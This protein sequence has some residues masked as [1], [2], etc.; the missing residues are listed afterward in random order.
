M[1]NSN[2]F[3]R[4]S[5][6]IALLF[7]NHLISQSIDYYYTINNN[8][9]YLYKQPNKYLLDFNSENDAMI[10]LQ[11]ITTS[12]VKLYSK[13]Y[14]V[15]D[16]DDSSVTTNYKKYPTYLTDQGNPMYYKDDIVLKFKSGVDASQINALMSSNNLT[17]L[18]TTVS[19]IQFKVQSDALQTSKTIY[20]TGLVEFCHPNFIAEVVGGYEGIK[21]DVSNIPEIL[22]P[23]GSFNSYSKRS[24]QLKDTAKKSRLATAIYLPSDEYF[25]KQWYLNNT[26]QM[27]NDGHIGT[28]DADID[29]PEAWD[30]TM[31]NNS[32]VVAVIDE[33]VSSNHPDL[34]NTRQ[35]RLP[36]S[37]I[38]FQFDGTNNPD[39][40]SPIFIAP[41]G[42]NHGNGCAGIIAATK[43]HEG[44][45]G[46]SPFCRIMPVKIIY[47]EYPATMCADAINFAVTNNTNI[48]NCSWAYNNNDPNFLPVIISAIE[49]AISNNIDVVFGAGNGANHNTSYNS[50]VAFPANNN[51]IGLI[52]V[53]ASDRNNNQ[54]NYSP[55]GT[56]NLDVVAPSHT[57]YNI[58]IP[59]EAFNIWTIDVPGELSGNNPYINAYPNDIPAVGETLPNGGTNYL[60][61]T[62]RFGGTSA[63]APQVAGV[64]ALVRS[65]NSCLSL[66][67]RKALIL[68]TADKVG[69]YNYASN[70]ALPGHSDELGYGKLN[71]FRAVSNAQFLNSPTLDLLVKDSDDDMGIQPNTTTLYPWASNDIW[72][73]NHND[74]LL[75]HQNPEYSP[76]VPNYAYIR[77]TNKSCVTSQANNNNIV[78]LYW[79]KAGT[80]LIWPISWNGSSTFSNNSLMGNL[81]GSVSIPQIAPGEEAIVR[82][83]FLVP[84]PS[85]YIFDGSDAW[86]FCL[87]ARIESNQD[88]MAIPETSDL[89]SNVLN[90]NNI[91]W[92]NITIVDLLANKLN[93]VIAVG[94]PF[95]EPRNFFLELVQDE[96]ET[97]K[98]V[99]DEAEVSLIMDDVLYAA[100]QRGGNESKLLGD[101][102]DEKTKIVKGN[103][104]KL[105]NIFFNPNEI[106]TLN[107]AFNF[108][109]KE[110]TDKTK[111]SYHVVQK[112]VETGNIIGG[113]TY[114]IKKAN[115]TLFY[116]DAG[117][118]KEV[119]QNQTIT[120][121]AADVNENA[122][123]N[124]YNANGNLVY[125]GKDLTVSADVITRYK[126]EVVATADG[127]KDY[128][129][130]NIN[131][132]PSNIESLS[133]NPADTSVVVN[134]K[135]NGISSAYLMVLGSYGTTG[136]L[137]NYILDNNSSSLSINTS[138]YSPG[139][140]IVALVCNGQIVD[141]KTLMKL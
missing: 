98:A 83:P 10:A 50:F 38:A 110:V 137:N 105:G 131:F 136:Q 62:G 65:V 80:S 11:N 33:G 94:N 132:K 76:T 44:V 91:A 37:N 13:S 93:G 75:E 55:N 109:T 22:K 69:T 138:A 111:Y 72:I 84:N 6:I 57:A 24:T 122:I 64:L 1:K 140:Y 36:G 60:S 134:Y 4:L 127:Y 30:I 78:R 43:N 118:D 41:K 87:L 2:L 63:A 81:I 32:M 45:V 51:T 92:K 23:N 71:A 120:I 29:A 113:E 15:S 104:A 46:V 49:N 40:P 117:G 8:K 77:I 102:R 86:H 31:G 26:G 68:R 74:G 20:E 59:G 106:G 28:A 128:S 112:D 54:A 133:P 42:W 126:L 129:E 19:Y 125:Q 18:K 17:L 108:L 121:T 123:Y 139:F 16:F 25:S 114:V 141:A 7:G 5:L 9:I 35:L 100:W 97:G 47:G 34:P 27:T 85:D 107:L 48:I 14:L 119:D 58:Q 12:K 90:N 79:A 89:V 99:Y 67:D 52:S 53:G 88:P 116:A 82:I 39:D 21:R 61:Y 101:T 103:H 115:R 135:L 3:T 96:S 56:Y 66:Q 70:A 124:W 95:N 130:I 73:R